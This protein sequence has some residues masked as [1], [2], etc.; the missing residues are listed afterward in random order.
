MSEHELPKAPSPL[1]PFEYWR[2]SLR[3]WSD[4]SQQSGKILMGQFGGMATGEK[5]SRALEPD[6]DTLATELLRTLADM[7]LRHWQNTA[8][9]LESYPAWLQVP[10]NMTGSALV[11]WFDTFQRQAGNTPPE[12][13]TSASTELEHAS[14]PERFDVPEG[15]ADDLTRIK[16]IGPKLSSRL[17][18]LGIYHFRQ[19]AAWSDED[20]IWIE[21]NLSSKGRVSREAWISQARLLSANGAATLH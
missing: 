13:T 6:A 5:K 21:D 16:G 19:I 18:A 10:H 3:V 4:F 14:R 12:A 20:A 15:K 17:N 1:S 2:E 9:L 11:D 7:N 8:R